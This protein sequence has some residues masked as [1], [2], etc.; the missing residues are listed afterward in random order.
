LIVNQF[1]IENGTPAFLINED[2]SKISFI[3]LS[4][5]YCR[6]LS[7][8]KVS[9]CESLDSKNRHYVYVIDYE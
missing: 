1:D 2:L 5:I 7:Y 3:D 6:N 9:H 8:S 4:Q